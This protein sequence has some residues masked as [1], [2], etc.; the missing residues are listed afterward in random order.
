MSRVRIL[1]AVAAL[2]CIWCTSAHAQPSILLSGTWG[3]DVNRDPFLKSFPAVAYLPAGTVV[4]KTEPSSFSANYVSVLTQNGFW[5]Q[6]AKPEKGGPQSRLLSGLSASVPSDTVFVHQSIFCLSETNRIVEPDKQCE[7]GTIKTPVGEG[8]IFTFTETKK[9]GWLLLS[10]TLNAHT[11][12]QLDERGWDPSET[13]FEIKKDDLRR[14]EDLGRVTLLNRPYPVV[15]FENRNL[16]SVYIEC[17]AK[18][19]TARKLRAAVS[20]TAE[21]GIKLSFFRW[22]EA[23]LG[24]AVEAEAEQSKEY[25]IEVDTT[26]ESYLYYMVAMHDHVADKKKNIRIEKKFECISGSK[27]EFGQKMIAVYVEIDSEDSP[28]PTAYELGD[29]GE[30]VLMQDKIYEFSRR[31]LFI[32]LN[33]PETYAGAVTRMMEKTGIRDR[34]L[35]EF[36]IANINYSCPGDSRQTKCASLVDLPEDSVTVGW[37]SS[38]SR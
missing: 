14:L 37:R 4:F 30:F 10:T 26:K 15:S 22:L 7:T 20:A 6:I 23:R 3:L 28:D 29:P 13:E 12:K 25:T 32:S 19:V 8:W 27:N 2:L 1:G 18:A 24:I 31:P 17:G 16:V 5:V 34:R 11:R 21:A 33:T 35:A 38:D 36:L 9:P